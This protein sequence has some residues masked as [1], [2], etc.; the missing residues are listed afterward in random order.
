V[1]ALRELLGDALA[2]LLGPRRARRA[3]VLS[4]WEEVVGQARAR[5]ARPVG[6]RGTT[7]V[8]VTDLPALLYELRLRRASLL[9]ALNERAGGQAIDDV[10]IVMRPSGIG[11]T[12][13]SAIQD[14][15]AGSSATSI[16]TDGR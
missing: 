16:R 4:A 14:G 11:A 2:A 8:V 15:I 3:A 1:Y 5:H 12:D 6:L 13:G 9:D 10:Q 7:L